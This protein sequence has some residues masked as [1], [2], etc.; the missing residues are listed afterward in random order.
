MPGVEINVVHPARL[1]CIRW[2]VLGSTGGVLLD[3]MKLGI[4]KKPERGLAGA[5]KV[6]EAGE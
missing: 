4:E 2:K 6:L 5:W 1:Y 3:W